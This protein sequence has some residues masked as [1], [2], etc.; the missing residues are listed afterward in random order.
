MIPAYIV[1]R[2]P[3]P[4]TILTWMMN[5]MIGFFISYTVGLTCSN[6]PP[7]GAA[8]AVTTAEAIEDEAWLAMDEVADMM[9]R[10]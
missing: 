5:R 7:C 6:I 2:A 1:R 3:K 10:S 8:L 4:L 9:P